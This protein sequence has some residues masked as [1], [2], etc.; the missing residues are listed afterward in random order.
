LAEK[1]SEGAEAELE[2]A[3]QEESEA[4]EERGPV[5]ALPRPLL[6]GGGIKARDQAQESDF[7]KESRQT[8]TDDCCDIAK[9]R[10]G[11]GGHRNKA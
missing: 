4:K 7:Q 6:D 1:T 10:G 3:S 8:G 5:E 2:A 11:N 9:G